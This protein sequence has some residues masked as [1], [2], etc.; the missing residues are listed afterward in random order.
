MRAYTLLVIYIATLLI[1][2]NLS[3]FPH[4]KRRI[5][6]IKNNKIMTEMSHIKYWGEYLETIPSL[7]YVATRSI[8]V[9]SGAMKYKIVR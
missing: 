6:I 3:S 7:V 5:S 2:I 9:S 8:D 1:S 4:I